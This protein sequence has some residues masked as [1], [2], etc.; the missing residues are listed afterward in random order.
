MAQNEDIILAAA[1]HHD[2]V[3]LGTGA[4]L[5]GTFVIELIKQFGPVLA[6]LLIDVIMKKKADPAKLGFSLTDA[7]SFDLGLV[8]SLL[9]ALIINY[10]PQIMSWLDVQENRLLDLII[11]KLSA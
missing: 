4:G 7:A 8:R 10:R 2:L 6:K 1:Q 5:A 3:K 9:V 11:E